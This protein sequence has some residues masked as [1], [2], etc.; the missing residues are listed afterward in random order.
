[1]LTIILT[2]SIACIL[3]TTL[4]FYHAKKTLNKVISLTNRMELFIEHM[5]KKVDFVKQK[6][7]DFIKDQECLNLVNDE[8]YDYIN[9]HNIDN[10]VLD[11]LK[12]EE[13]IDQI[14]NHVIL[15][16]M[17]EKRCKTVYKFFEDLKET[18]EYKNLNINK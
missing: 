7:I 18:E 2:I 5:E 15:K 14:Y 4:Q 6:F 10:I 17:K 1:M 12:L 13:S 3:Y 11:E 8:L 9:E 16:M